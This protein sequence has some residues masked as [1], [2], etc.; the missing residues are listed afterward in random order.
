MLENKNK[1]M[2]EKIQN[3]L[4]IKKSGKHG[5]TQHDFVTYANFD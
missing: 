4:E 1:K 5:L 2:A 3:Y